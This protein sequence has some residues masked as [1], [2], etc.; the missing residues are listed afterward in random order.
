MRCFFLF[1]EVKIF[2]LFADKIPLV[3]GTYRGHLSRGM[4]MPRRPVAG[5]VDPGECDVE[6]RYPRSPGL[7]AAGYRQLCCPVRLT[8]TGLRQGAAT[9]AQPSFNNSVNSVNSVK[10]SVDSF[11]LQKPEKMSEDTGMVTFFEV[12]IFALFADKIPLIPNTCRRASKRFSPSAP[13]RSR[14]WLLR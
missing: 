9:A 11:K 7:T 10:K 12:K 1:F 4:P 2:A 14:C 5:G 8:P 3:P 13:A 6:C